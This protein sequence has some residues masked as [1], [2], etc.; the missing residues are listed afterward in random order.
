[1]S[2]IP[3]RQALNLPL[4]TIPPH[5]FAM[6]A[7]AQT[8]RRAYMKEV[9]ADVL[10]IMDQVTEQEEQTEQAEDGGQRRNGRASKKGVDE[11]R[12]DDN[13]ADNRYPNLH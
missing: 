2:A 7:P 6:R 5:P 12:R 13:G 10:R 4:P 11:D 9:I 1:M 3:L 8:D